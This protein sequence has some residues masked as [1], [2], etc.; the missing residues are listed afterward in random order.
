M[1]LEVDLGNTRIKWRL[2][3]ESGSLASGSLDQEPLESLA[4]QFTRQA[5]QPRQIWVASVRPQ[6][7]NADLAD[8]CYRLWQLSP[9]FAQTQAQTA[10][11]VNA[12]RDHRQM[13]VDRW[14]ALLA[15]HRAYTDP[16]LVVQ[17][18]TAL[19]VDLLAPDGRHLG[20]YIGPGW[21]LMRRA[22]AEQTAQV[23]LPVQTPSWDID[24]GYSTAEAVKAA[25][26][27]MT[28]GLIERG[29][30]VLSGEA[31]KP[32]VIVGGGDGEGL[33]AVLGDAI[34]RPELVLDGLAPAYEGGALLFQG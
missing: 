24:P 4:R 6:S 28:L 25:L 20:G 32:R 2:R 14:L 11:L 34:Y 13:G 33:A 3:T 19:T 7:A 23:R 9:G 30:A 17:A 26:A 31:G 27:A 29:R 1:I 10:G 5:W 21:Q 18:G 8:Q 15:A 12:Y 16:V 22:L